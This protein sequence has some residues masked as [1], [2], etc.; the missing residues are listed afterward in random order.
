MLLRCR[1]LQGGHALLV[2]AGTDWASWGLL[3]VVSD[4]PAG[5]YGLRDVTL[6]AAAW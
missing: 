5:V 3:D 6:M 2:S 1:L 4:I